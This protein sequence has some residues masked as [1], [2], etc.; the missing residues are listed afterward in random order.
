MAGGELLHK[1]GDDVLG[2]GRDR[3][4]AELA[5]GDP[6]GLASGAPALA[7]GSTLRPNLTV[8]SAPTSLESADTAAETDGCVT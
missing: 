7:L 1:L 8:K 4:D 2:G 3:R 6:R 5:L